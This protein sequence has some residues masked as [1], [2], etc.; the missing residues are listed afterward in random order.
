[1]EKRK[2]IILKMLLYTVLYVIGSVIVCMTGAVHPALF[3]CYQLTAGLL[4]GGVAYKAFEN[5]RAGAAVCL[6]AGMVLT[7]F[8]IQDAVA[9]HVLPLVVIAAAAEAIRS[10]F[11]Y[12]RK[13]NIIAA[14]IMTFS[15]FGY[16]GQI[17]FNRSYTYDCA[18]EE[19]PEGYADKLMNAS[20]AWS[21]PVVVIG[22]I[23]LAVVMIKLTEKL[24]ERK[25]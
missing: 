21:L 4:L 22:G 10:L 11:A 5:M 9:W 6:S 7:L 2:S 3:V 16:Y 14:V 1:M 20:P 25:R 24:T 13:G 8:I 15:T 12:E 18:V 23:L 17:W 19:M